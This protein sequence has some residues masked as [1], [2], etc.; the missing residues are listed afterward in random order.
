L[1][2]G[3]GRRVEDEHAEVL[4][5]Y[6][7]A[8]FHSG[9]MSTESVVDEPIAFL[10]FSRYCLNDTDWNLDQVLIDGLL[11]TN[12]I[13]RGFLLE[14]IVGYLLLKLFET[15]TPLSSVFTFVGNCDIGDSNAYVIA[16]WKDDNNFQFSPFNIDSDERA[17]YQ[18]G[19]SPHDASGFLAWLQDPHRLPLCLPCN[20]LGPDIVLLLRL[21]NGDLLRVIIQVKHRNDTLFHPKEILDA[22]RTTDP[23]Q[24]LSELR[25]VVCLYSLATAS[26]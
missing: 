23:K 6:G 19:C 3:G 4:V 22:F 12:P 2:V 7:F 9:H 24:F 18:I 14:P 16:A 21:T 8:R 10:S 1:L 5:E 13:V 17:G 26:N 15:P 20:A 11:T 25:Q